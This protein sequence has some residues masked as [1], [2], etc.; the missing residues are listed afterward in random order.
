MEK[1]ISLRNALLDMDEWT[2]VEDRTPA[3]LVNMAEYVVKYRF[4]SNKGNKRKCSNLISSNLAALSEINPDK[5]IGIMEIMYNYVARE[6]PAY[7]DED[8]DDPY[9]PQVV[10]LMHFLQETA[11]WALQHDEDNRLTLLLLRMLPEDGRPIKVDY[12]EHSAGV[13]KQMSLKDALSEYSDHRF[14][15][16]WLLSGDNWR[17]YPE[18]LLHRV[19]GFGHRLSRQS[20]ADAM[21]LKGLF[22]K[23]YAVR[24]LKRQTKA[25]RRQIRKYL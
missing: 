10:L 12:R 21:R 4:Y 20:V 2:K 16:S 19:T 5:T 24:S 6:L 1:Y 17:S 14:L 18:F 22:A 25:H 8:I 15:V 13:S 23:H 9:D 3:D 7:W 11:V